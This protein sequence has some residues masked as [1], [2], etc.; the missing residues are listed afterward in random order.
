M[1][2]PGC[3]PMRTEMMAVM[4]SGITSA[5]WASRYACAVYAADVFPKNPWYTTGAKYA[6]FRRVLA[7]NTAIIPI[8]P[9]SHAPFTRYHLVTKPATGGAP[10]MLNEAR[11]KAPKVNGIARPNPL[12]SEMF[13]L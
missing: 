10:I 3:N 1:K 12:I 2:N 5:G 7:S 9:A 13:F 4:L 6:A 11:A 8:E